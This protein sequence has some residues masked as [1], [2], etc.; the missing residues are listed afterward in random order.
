M[1]PTAKATLQKIEDSIDQLGR[2]LPLREEPRVSAVP[3][4]KAVEWAARKAK[5]GA[6]L[7]QLRWSGIS[8]QGEH[9]FGHAGV[10]AEI[11]RLEGKLLRIRGQ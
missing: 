10:I 4:E 5:I 2:S 8:S 11:D 3:D 1:D 9:T 6:M 7:Y